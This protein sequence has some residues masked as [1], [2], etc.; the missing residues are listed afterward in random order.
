MTFL[1]SSADLIINNL[2]TIK[3]YTPG[4]NGITLREL[5]T[6]STDATPTF[7]D[8]V[9]DFQPLDTDPVEAGVQIGYDDLGNVIQD[10][11]S[12]G[13]RS[14][15]LNGSGNNDQMNGEAL[16][17]RLTAL[18]GSDILTGGSD[19]DVLIGQDG[20]DQLFSDQ[21]VNVSGLVSFEN[22][23]GTV[24]TG[25]PG[26]FLTGGINDDVLVSGADDLDAEERIASHMTCCSL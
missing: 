20:N 8:I 11:Q 7:R 24:G 16:R 25:A 2:L 4:Q 13:D 21:L 14:D 19:G 10:P 15:L 23:G 26:D 12:H 5:P 9:G 6:V 18:G 3:N 1:L 17:D 22:F